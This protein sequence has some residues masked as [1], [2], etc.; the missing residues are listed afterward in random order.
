MPT[1][2][3]QAALL[4]NGMD[5]VMIVE[6]MMETAGELRKH[7][8]ARPKGLYPGGQRGATVVVAAVVVVGGNSGQIS[9]SI[10]GNSGTASL[11][12]SGKSIIPSS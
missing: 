7:S 10:S 4:P 8:F 1:F 6:V 2:D 9:R 12:S 3:G 11:S 5:C